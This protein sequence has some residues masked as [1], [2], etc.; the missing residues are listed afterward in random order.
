MEALRQ[1]ILALKFG[2]LVKRFVILTLCVVLLGTV[3][4]AGMLRPQISQAISAAQSIEKQDLP[5]GWTFQDHPGYHGYDDRTAL[6]RQISEPSAP[7]KITLALFAGALLLLFAA[8]WLLVPAWLYQASKRS[9]MNGLLWPTLGLVWN[10]WAVLLFLTARSLLRQRCGT[11][12]S[13][14]KRA[15]YC[16]ACG[17]NLLVICPSCKETCD[18][19]S[20]YCP[21][22]G[23]PLQAQAAASKA[24][25]AR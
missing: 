18:P 14:Q 20:L 10:L 9:K 13:W 8:Y 11:C 3:L 5:E 16:H 6:F 25:E 15:P 23:T 19:G 2:P 21:K 22:C 7:A 17:K 12:G 1:K 4:S 24:E